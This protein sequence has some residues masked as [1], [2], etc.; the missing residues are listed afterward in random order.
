M[1]PIL[2]T[3]N[4]SFDIALGKHKNET[5]WKNTTMFWSDFVEK[6]SVTVRTAETYVEYCTAT[7]QR[8]EEIKNG[9]AFVGGF[10]QGGRR[11]KGNVLHRQL[12]V[13]DIDNGVPGI[14]EEFIFSYSVA[15]AY[16]T[17]HKHC[18][19]APRLRLVIP[20][21]REVGPDEYGA[22][23]RRI[24]G[25]LGIEYFDNTGFEPSRLM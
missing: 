16:Y 5:H 13:L 20:L 23:G 15:G 19:K 2:I 21:D 11:K 22:I 10:V 9:P 1:P 17:T 24:A 18:A 6:L 7:K 25:V 4:A 14:W 12:L 3:Q 8:Q